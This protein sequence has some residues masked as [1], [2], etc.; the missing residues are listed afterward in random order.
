VVAAPLAQAE[1]WLHHRDGKRGHPV[2]LQRYLKI[3]P[4]IARSANLFNR[5]LAGESKYL[6]SQ[7]SWVGNTIVGAGISATDPTIPART[8]GIIGLTG[9]PILR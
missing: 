5:R 8:V 1:G 6:K 9:L 4:A 2:L 7:R 3:V